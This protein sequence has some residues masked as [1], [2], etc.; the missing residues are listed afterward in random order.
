M[1]S[2]LQ[3]NIA[4]FSKTVLLMNMKFFL[5]KVSI[6]VNIQKKFHVTRSHSI[7]EKCDDI[8]QNLKVVY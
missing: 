8:L 3:V 4:F 1:Q 6:R 7:G 2:Y 5:Y